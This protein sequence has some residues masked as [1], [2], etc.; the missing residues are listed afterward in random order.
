P[1][2]IELF[3]FR[4]SGPFFIS[5]LK[6]EEKAAIF[7]FDGT[8]VASPINFASI[9]LLSASIRLRL[10]LPHIAVLSKIDL[11]AEKLPM[12]LEWAHSDSALQEALAGEKEA[13]HS[14]IGSEVARIL[15]RSGFASDLVP[16]SSATSEGLMELDASV[17]RALNQGDAP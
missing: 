11:L 2:Q 9:S 4:A 1:G 8:L 13:E 10:N 15:S 12:I 6:A 16:V 14:F 5:N 3:A 17:A 7:V